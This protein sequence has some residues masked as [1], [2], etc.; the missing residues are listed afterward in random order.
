MAAEKRGVVVLMGAMFRVTRNICKKQIV[1][2]GDG[3]YDELD[4]TE[5]I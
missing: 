4:H 5:W 3:T 1:K 2:R